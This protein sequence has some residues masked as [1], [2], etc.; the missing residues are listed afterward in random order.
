M[1]LGNLFFSTEETRKEFWRNNLIITISSFPL[2]MILLLLF[3]TYFA[4]AWIIAVAPCIP[5][6][7]FIRKRFNLAY[8]WV[9]C[10]VNGIRGYSQKGKRFRLLYSNIS[11]VEKY[12]D[13]VEIFDNFENSHTVY[14]GK[15]TEAVV[16][17][18]NTKIA[19]TTTKNSD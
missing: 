12:K 3:L 19:I 10:H 14:T 6:G 16:T 15:D 2:F 13:R 1:E 18:I 11:H 17:I 9:N 8:S 7:I 4:Q 5:F